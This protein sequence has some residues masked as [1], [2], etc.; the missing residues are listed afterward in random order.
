MSSKDDLQNTM[1][2]EIREALSVVPVPAHAMTTVQ[3]VEALGVNR[4]RISPWL[5]EEV[6]SGRWASSRIGSTVYYWK[7]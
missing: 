1:L 5:A 4:H 3:L 6:K 7:V 2:E